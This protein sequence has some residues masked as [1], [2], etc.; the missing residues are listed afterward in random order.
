LENEVPQDSFH[1]SDIATDTRVFLT[2]QQAFAFFQ[3]GIKVPRRLLDR[4]GAIHM[5][6]QKRKFYG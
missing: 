6:A 2:P 4:S 5:L 3:C 1:P